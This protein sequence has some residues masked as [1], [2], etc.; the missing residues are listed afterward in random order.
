MIGS[1]VAIEEDLDIRRRWPE[2]SR[3][4]TSSLCFLLLGYILDLL[5]NRNM[6]YRKTAVYGVR[7][8]IEEWNHGAAI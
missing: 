1:N 7:R 5:M 8:D 4:S 6:R 3:S 2:I